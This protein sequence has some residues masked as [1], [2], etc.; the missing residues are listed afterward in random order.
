MFNLYDSL[1][2]IWDWICPKKVAVFEVPLE[3]QG[4]FLDYLDHT[5]SMITE[6][7][8]QN[9]IDPR[10]KQVVQLIE[11]WLGGKATPRFQTKKE[12]LD[13]VSGTDGKS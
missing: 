3:L 2:S 7:E 8:I 1:N 5:Q 6:E 12:L 10:L 11:G 13:I 9:C 4:A